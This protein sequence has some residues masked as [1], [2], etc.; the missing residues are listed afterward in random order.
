MVA[1]A[2]AAPQTLASLLRALPAPGHPCPDPGLVS[3]ATAL[4]LLWGSSCPCHPLP[5]PHHPKTSPQ[6]LLC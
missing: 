4:G 3:A 6:P 1:A 2:E 5:C